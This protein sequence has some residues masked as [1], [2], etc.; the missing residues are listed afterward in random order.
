MDSVGG[1][2]RALPLPPPRPE[3]LERLLARR[4]PVLE[5]DEVDA[6]LSELALGDPRLRPPET[7]SDLDLGQPGIDAG[8]LQAFE[9]RPVALGLQRLR[10]A[11]GRRSLLPAVGYTAVGY[12][13]ALRPS[14]TRSL[15]AR[16]APDGSPPV[17]GQSARRTAI[18][19]LP[20][21]TRRDR[22]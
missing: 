8:P 2:P 20:R 6:T 3:P 4:R 7:R 16:L 18:P 11:H 17:P 19:A 9:E 14:P 1:G 22:P 12:A 21:G 15:P 10:R 13:A 5:L